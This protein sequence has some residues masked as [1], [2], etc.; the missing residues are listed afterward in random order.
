M[1]AAHSIVSEPEFERT[2]ALPAPNPSFFRKYW[3]FRSSYETRLDRQDRSLTRSSPALPPSVPPR[4]LAVRPI[5]RLITFSQRPSRKSNPP[6]P[7]SSRNAPSSNEPSR[8][9]SVSPPRRKHDTERGFLFWLQFCKSRSESFKFVPLS[10]IALRRQLLM[11][12][13]PTVP[14]CLGRRQGT[15]L[16]LRRKLVGRLAHFLPF[17]RRRVTAKS[18]E[19]TVSK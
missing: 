9:R 5:R 15:F 11:A 19:D 2:S 8:V 12:L 10:C 13:A 17:S 1:S 14:S 7:P 3:A 6:S 4:A 18:T 16:F